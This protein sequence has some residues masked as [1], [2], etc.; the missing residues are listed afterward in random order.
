MTLRQCICKAS[1][2][3]IPEEHPRVHLHL[4]ICL[5]HSLGGHHCCLS[6]EDYNLQTNA[7]TPKSLL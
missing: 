7:L 6:V 1:M 4:L 3:W 2:H 5:I